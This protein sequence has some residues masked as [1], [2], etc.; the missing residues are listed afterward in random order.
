MLFY[1]LVLK[2]RFP[3]KN[4]VLTYEQI[5]AFR[6]NAFGFKG[7]IGDLDSNNPVLKTR[8]QR[9][10]PFVP[11]GRGEEWNIERIKTR[12]LAYAQHLADNSF[13]LTDRDESKACAYCPYERICRKT[14]LPR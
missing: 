5:K 6:N 9:A 14:A 8:P 12:T 2:S 10:K 1:Y 11:I 4:V 3:E 13:P 7:Y